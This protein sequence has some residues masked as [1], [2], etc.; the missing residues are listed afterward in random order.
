MGI[1]DN[2]EELIL[3]AR[4]RWRI[5][6]GFNSLKKRGFHFEHNFGHGKK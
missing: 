6:N 2:I 1:Q 3:C 5:E 4:N